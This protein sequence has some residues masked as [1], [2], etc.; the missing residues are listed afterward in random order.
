MHVLACNPGVGG[1]LQ[2]PVNTDTLRL[3]D[4]LFQCWSRSCWPN[5]ENNLSHWPWILWHPPT[6]GPVFSKSYPPWRV[7]RPG[8]ST[9]HSSQQYVGPH[10]TYAGAWLSFIPWTCRLISPIGPH[11]SSYTGPIVGPIWGNATYD[12]SRLSG[13]S[14]CPWCLFCRLYFWHITE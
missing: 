6:L 8:N 1:V 3:F 2:S 14:Q 10:S 7:S 11:F 4:P 12:D 13:P 9:V 5:F